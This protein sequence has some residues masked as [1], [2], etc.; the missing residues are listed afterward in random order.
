M[1]VRK[2]TVK[3][4]NEES[5]MNVTEEEYRNYYRP[6]WQQKKH[7]QRNREAMEQNGYTEESY[8]EWK[9]NDMRTEL[10]AESMEELAE[11]RMLLGVLQDAMDSLLPEER[12]LA[13]K[14]F[15]EEMQVSEFAKSKNESRTTVSSR[16]QRVLEKLLN[17]IPL[18]SRLEMV[19]SIFRATTTYCGSIHV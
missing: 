11:K 13:M 1:S 12:E 9:E 14:V 6:W 18:G 17:I 16:K 5:T 4:G 2:I 3:S 15:G 8:E 7:E 10:F 19:F